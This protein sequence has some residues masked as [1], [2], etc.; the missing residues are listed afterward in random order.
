MNEKLAEYTSLFKAMEIET[1]SIVKKNN[2]QEKAAD[3][4][5]SASEKAQGAA[6][7][8][9]RT[10]NAKRAAILAAA[11]ADRNSMQ[12]NADEIVAA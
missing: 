2:A 3:K 5:A 9:T 11:E 4:A 7:R 6:D 8:K 1:S 10:N 12:K